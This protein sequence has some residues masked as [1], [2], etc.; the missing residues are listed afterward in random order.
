MDI[1]VVRIT[2][3]RLEGKIIVRLFRFSFKLN[4]L[5]LAVFISTFGFLTDRISLTFVYLYLSHVIAGLF[6]NF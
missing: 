4:T 3:V 6:Y 1:L 2:R 5:R